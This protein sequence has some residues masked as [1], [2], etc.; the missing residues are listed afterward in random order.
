MVFRGLPRGFFFH[1]IFTTF[2][3]EPRSCDMASMGRHLLQVRADTRR[4]QKVAAGARSSLAHRPLGARRSSRAAQ[5]VGCWIR[6]MAHGGYTPS[7]GGGRGEREKARSGM[8]AHVRVL[9]CSLCAACCRAQ[10]AGQNAPAFEDVARLDGEATC[11]SI[12][13]VHQFM[14]SLQGPPGS[15]GETGAYGGACAYVHAAYASSRAHARAKYIHIHRLVYPTRASKPDP[16][17]NRGLVTPGYPKRALCD[18]IQSVWCGCVS[19]R[20]RKGRAS[21]EHHP[22][23]IFPTHTRSRPA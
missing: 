4:A 16:S 18:E 14:N 21:K 20:A 10:N 12:E 13:D 5:S 23:D 8:C 19:E 22:P 3:E 2:C 1:A 17:E 15:G 9:R 7:S 11:I 6:R